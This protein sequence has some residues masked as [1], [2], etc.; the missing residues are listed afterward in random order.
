M[1]EIKAPQP[2]TGE[3]PF[4]FL[5]GSIEMGK[6][7]DWQT[8]VAGALAGARITILNPRRPDWDSSW[9]QSINDHNFRTQVE[10]EL[11]ALERADQILL[12]LEPGTQ[13]PISL[14][15]F[16]LYARSGKLKVVCPDG[17]WR[18]G[19]IDVVCARYCVDQF[20]NLRDAILVIFGS[21]EREPE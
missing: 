3:G 20:E 9:V 10:W 17:F 19:N 2:I 5:A 6:A 18:K 16:G 4:L 21:L 1:R 8:S 11:R 7:V 14:L 13:S 15:E 12:Y